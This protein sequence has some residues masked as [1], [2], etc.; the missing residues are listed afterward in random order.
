MAQRS[1]SARLARSITGMVFAA[2]YAAAFVAAYID[3]RGNAGAWLADLALVLIALPFTA[4]MNV[5]SGGA[6][7]FGGAD[8]GKV[9][10]AALF[11]CALAWLCGAALEALVRA[12]VRA[13][14]ARA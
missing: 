7:D 13:L 10:A 1:L 3:Y 8:T 2:L 5:L 9:I 6:F 11:C 12:A 4:T 14:R